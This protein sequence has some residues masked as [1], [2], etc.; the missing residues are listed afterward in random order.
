MFERLGTE[1][2][3]YY[4]FPFAGPEQ[5]TLRVLYASSMVAFSPL[6][7]PLEQGAAPVGHGMHTQP[8]GFCRQETISKA[9]SKEHRGQL[10][11][12][13]PKLNWEPAGLI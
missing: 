2:G 8:L 11:K 9:R 12:S 4:S 6:S 7:G 3:L 10:A 13:E 5:R 1:N